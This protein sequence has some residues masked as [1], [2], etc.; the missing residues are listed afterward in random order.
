MT[1]TQ[2]PETSTGSGHCLCGCG[3]IVRSMGKSVYRPGHDARHAGQVARYVAES[4]DDGAVAALPTDA[5]RSKAENMVLRLRTKAQAQADL[6]AARASR[7]AKAAKWTYGEAKKGRWT[8]PTRTN[9]R[10][11]EINDKRDGSGNWAEL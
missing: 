7:P 9:G 1:K 11:T 10:V 3:D 6:E 4:G 2:T 5:L 8:Y